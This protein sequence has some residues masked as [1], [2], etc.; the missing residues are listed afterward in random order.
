[1]SR[2][3]AEIEKRTNLLIGSFQNCLVAFEKKPPF[4]AYQRTFHIDCINLRRTCGSAAEAVTDS[5]FLRALYHTLQAWGIGQR[6]SKLVTFEQFVSAMTA[7]AK[8]IE[9]LEKF[10]LVDGGLDVAE[11]A[12]KLWTVI[13]HLRIVENEAT[14]V[15]GSKALHHVL[16]DLVVP[17]DRAYTGLFFG[18]HP[19]EFQN[20]HR[21]LRQGFPRFVRIATQV[22]P[23][24]FVKSDGGWHTSTSKVIDNAVIGFCQLVK[25]LAQEASKKQG[26]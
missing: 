4:T 15:A 1:M 8:D 13:D 17:M 19:P 21:L 7:R 2:R 22:N 18:W 16:P 23:Q 24:R 12:D 10:T 25:E 14:L 26:G 6:A 11:V 20:G 5:N 9:A 3:D